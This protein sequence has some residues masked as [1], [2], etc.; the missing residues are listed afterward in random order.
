VGAAR[1]DRRFGVASPLRHFNIESTQGRRR[2]S[3]RCPSAGAH[4]AR[5]SGAA[6]R[7]LAIDVRKR[8]LCAILAIRQVI[9]NHKGEAETHAFMV[10]GQ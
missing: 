1:L 5:Q 7:L 2:E 6:S 9:L 4:P 3:A 10:T 8:R